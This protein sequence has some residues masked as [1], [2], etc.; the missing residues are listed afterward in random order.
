MIAMIILIALTRLEGRIAPGAGEYIIGFGG[1]GCMFVTVEV[2]GSEVY[3][4]LGDGYILA[5]NAF[6]KLRSSN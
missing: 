3:R 4:F 5:S 6:T 2:A 1:N